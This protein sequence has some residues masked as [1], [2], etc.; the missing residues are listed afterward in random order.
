MTRN[1]DSSPAT[2][3]TQIITPAGPPSIRL[4]PECPGWSVAPACTSTENTSKVHV[5]VHTGVKMKGFRQ[6]VVSRHYGHWCSCFTARSLPPIITFPTMQ[7]MVETL[8]RLKLK[9]TLSRQLIQHEQLS[10]AKDANKSSKKKDSSNSSQNQASLG[11]SQ[12][13]QAA[14]PGQ[15][16]PTSSTT[17]LND[18]RGK[19]PDN[20][21]PAGTPAAGVTSAQHYI[22]QG[23]GI[24]GQPISNGPG[25]PTRQG[26][27]VAPSVIISPSGPVSAPTRLHHNTIIRTE[28]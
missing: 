19:S 13:Q 28:S 17:S 23:A 6:R 26:Q 9:L 24:A 8:T 14:S 7:K 20:A 1:A 10:R 4:P 18:A 21:S 16:T 12:T 27:P 15:G 11:I 2:R 22:P 3:S 25:T 5:I